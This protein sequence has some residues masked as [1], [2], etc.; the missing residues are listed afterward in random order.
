MDGNQLVTT[1]RAL[2]LVVAFMPRIVIT[3]NRASGLR[4]HLISRREPPAQPRVEPGLA[5]YSLNEAKPSSYSTRRYYDTMYPRL[6]ACSGSPDGVLRTFYEWFES[7]AHIFS[8]K[9]RL[10]S[11]CIRRFKP[12]KKSRQRGMITEFPY[13]SLAHTTH[14]LSADDK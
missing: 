6:I 12:R 9:H 10:A 8:K 7:N 14:H 3:E 13:N 1:L 11:A 2:I 5:S 4:M